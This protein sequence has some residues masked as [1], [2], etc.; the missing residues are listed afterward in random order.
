[1]S[2]Q[3]FAN[4]GPSVTTRVFTNCKKLIAR[5]KTSRIKSN[6]YQALLIRMISHSAGTFS[7]LKAIG[8]SK[9]SDFPILNGARVYTA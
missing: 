8:A 5:V 1:M 6:E 3:E 2:T 9:H 4:N 7:F